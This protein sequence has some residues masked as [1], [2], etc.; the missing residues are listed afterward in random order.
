MYLDQN[1]SP[2][3]WMALEAKVGR[4]PARMFGNILRLNKSVAEPEKGGNYFSSF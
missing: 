3:F 1:R 2:L 4:D